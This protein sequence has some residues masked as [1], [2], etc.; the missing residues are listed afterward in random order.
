VKFPWF[1]FALDLAEVLI[2]SALIGRVLGLAAAHYW[3]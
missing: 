1:R 2:L 3:Q